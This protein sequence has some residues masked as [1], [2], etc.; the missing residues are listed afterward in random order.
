MRLPLDADLLH[1]RLQ[2]R[3]NAAF[4][5][6]GPGCFASQSLLAFASRA[7]QREESQYKMHRQSV[8]PE[9]CF[10]AMEVAVDSSPVPA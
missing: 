1:C 3:G 2:D 4:L 7:G 5:A 10:A 8:I 9:D 6:L